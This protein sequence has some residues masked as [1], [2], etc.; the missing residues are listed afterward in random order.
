RHPSS[1][2][3]RTAPVEIM[4]Q[5]AYHMDQ[6][7]MAAACQQN[8][9]ICS[10][11]PTSG[12]SVL[13]CRGLRVVS[14]LYWLSLDLYWLPTSSQ[15]PI[16]TVIP[17]LKHLQHLSLSGWKGNNNNNSN[18]NNNNNDNR[19]HASASG[20]LT[21][22]LQSCTALR[23]VGLVENDT[24]VST[25]AFWELRQ[26]GLKTQ[27]RASTLNKSTLGI[28]LFVNL[29]RCMPQLQHVSLQGSVWTKR[30]YVFCER[31]LKHLMMSFRVQCPLLRSVNVSASRCSDHNKTFIGPLYEALLTETMETVE[32]SN[33]YVF[34]S[35]FL[36][37]LARRC[38]RTLTHLD[39]GHPNLHWD[40]CFHAINYYGDYVAGV[41]EVLQSCAGLDFLDVRCY[42]IDAQAIGAYP[43]A[44]SRLRTLRICI[45]YETRV[46]RCTTV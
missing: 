21:N 17:Q 13:D 16:V 38:F 5:I 35:A 15:D 12:I 4:A 39:M 10:K 30:P 22:I 8:A 11:A 23:T 37:T 33:S 36:S 28:E 25:N 7:S 3:A 43:W 26:L 6:S 34:P 27:I 40:P 20:V 29:T 2:A 19:N 9:H 1:T 18:N 41:L 32:V 31:E 46:C 45:E 42:P 44:A 24:L 14:I